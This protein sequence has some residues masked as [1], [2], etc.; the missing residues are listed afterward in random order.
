MHWRGRGT[1][2]AR[3]RGTG[4]TGGGGSTP[5]DYH[6]RL[7]RNLSV[8]A[9]HTA[10][11]PAWIG[12]C[13]RR[14]RACKSSGARSV[15]RENTVFTATSGPPE[16]CGAVRW[17]SRAVARASE[18]AQHPRCCGTTAA[19][20]AT[21]PWDPAPPE[22]RSVEPRRQVASSTRRPF[23]GADLAALQTLIDRQVPSIATP[24][25]SCGSSLSYAPTHC[26][27]HSS[28]F[29]R[30]VADHPAGAEEL[31]FPPNPARWRDARSN[32]SRPPRCP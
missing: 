16:R 5:T 18:R 20:A 32:P 1:G 25:P 28:R 15:R 11:V 14:D 2:T 29:A 4:R 13:T 12:E 8:L 21:P 7:T 17:R 22:Q 9:T 10:A 30:R 26:Q 27:A 23:P 19:P 3:V 6:R 24:R 31:T